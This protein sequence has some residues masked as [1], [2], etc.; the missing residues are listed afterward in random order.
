MGATGGIVCIKHHNCNK[1][2]RCVSISMGCVAITGN[3]SFCCKLILIQLFNI[4]C[5]QFFVVRYYKWC[6]V[7]FEWE[8]MV[9]CKGQKSSYRRDC[10]VQKKLDLDLIFLRELVGFLVL[11]P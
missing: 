11:A 1:V 7:E 3:Q 9:Y 4:Y 6:S 2:C 5:N 8:E 10:F